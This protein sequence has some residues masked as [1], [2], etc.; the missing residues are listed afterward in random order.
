[1]KA[2]T[3]CVTHNA[4]K[5]KTLLRETMEHTLDSSLTGSLLTQVTP[6]HLVPGLRH[7][8]KKPLKAFLTKEAKTVITIRVRRMG[9]ARSTPWVGC[10]Q[11]LTHICF[12]L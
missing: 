2:S 6:R 7:G 10:S 9:V 11:V 1:M 12:M 5:F 8:W 4:A 3:A